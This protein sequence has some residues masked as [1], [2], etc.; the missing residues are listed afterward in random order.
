MFSVFCVSNSP[1]LNNIFILK[2]TSKG[3]MPEQ[4]DRFFQLQITSN[5]LQMILASTSNGLLLI[6]GQTQTA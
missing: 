3:V 4:V 1:W 6:K 5:Q 2:L